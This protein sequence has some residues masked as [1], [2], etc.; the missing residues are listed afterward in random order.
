MSTF[1]NS[2]ARSSLRST[3]MSILVAYASKDGA[4]GQ[5]AERIA[6]SL[7]RRDSTPRLDLSRRRIWPIAT[8][9]SVWRHS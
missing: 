9:S 5:I 6:E 8:G 3:E 2:S 1:T 7:G 4:A